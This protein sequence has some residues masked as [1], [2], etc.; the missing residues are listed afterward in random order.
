MT[1]SDGRNLFLLGALI[2]VLSGVILGSVATI[3]L[4]DRISGLVRQLVRKISDRQR[5]VRFELLGQ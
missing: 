5:S 3:E 2:G 4:G 1:H